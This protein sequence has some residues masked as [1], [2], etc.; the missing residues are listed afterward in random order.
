[1]SKPTKNYEITL[2]SDKFIANQPSFTLKPS[3]NPLK[4][5]APDTKQTIADVIEIETLL[6]PLII[7]QSGHFRLVF[8][9]ECV[10]C[11]MSFYLNGTCELT[12]TW[13]CTEFSFEFELKLGWQCW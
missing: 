7:K 4:H 1:M 9:N 8:V 10:A 13:L 6:R 3:K 11:G 12:R 5:P 2:R